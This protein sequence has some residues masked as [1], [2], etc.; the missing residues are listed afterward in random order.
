MAFKTDGSLFLLS[1][2]TVMQR[3]E[4]GRV[5]LGKEPTAPRVNGFLPSTQ[6]DVEGAHALRG[7][8]LFGP[9]TSTTKQTWFG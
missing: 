2:F 1:E 8:S 7:T 9:S 6:V 5:T 4:G 3:I